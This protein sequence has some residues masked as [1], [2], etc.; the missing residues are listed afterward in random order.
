MLMVAALVI[1]VLESHCCNN[2]NLN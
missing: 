1:Y 2:A